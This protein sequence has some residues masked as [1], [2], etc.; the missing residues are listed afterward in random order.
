MK[1]MN[2]HYGQSRIFGKARFMAP[3]LGEGAETDANL[4]NAG[5]SGDNNPDADDSD[6]DD[7]PS[8]DD[9]MAQLAKA[10]A[11][12]QKMKI[13]SDKNAAQAKQYKDQARAHMTAEQQAQ[14]ARAD[15]D[16]EFEALKKEVRVTKYS[17]R[18]VGIGMDEAQADE[19]ANIIPE[20]EDSDAFFDA[21]NTFVTSVKKTSADDAIQKLLKE[22]PEINAGGGDS[23][24]DD[25]SIAFAK[26][27]I[28]QR[29]KSG[30]N[31]DIL[32]NFM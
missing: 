31:A 6:N 15:R 30:V 21:L 1:Y 27:F 13:Q 19:M 28:S 16:A 20:M 25:P 24:K 17:K 18:L 26:N 10:Q 7:S 4:D 3:E 29:S 14:A 12:Y 5:G 2:N 22:R 8:V 23:D 9:L 11:D 32:K